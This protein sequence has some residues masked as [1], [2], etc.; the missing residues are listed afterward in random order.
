[1]SCID[2]SLGARPCALTWSTVPFGSPL[3]CMSNISPASCR[4]RSS[5]L[6]RQWDQF[7]LSTTRSL[8]DVEPSPKASF[9][10]IDD[11][12]WCYH[13]GT[14]YRLRSCYRRHRFC[15]VY[16]E[17][18]EGRFVLTTTHCSGIL[19]ASL[20]RGNYHSRTVRISGIW[21]VLQKFHG[22]NR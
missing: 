1:M 8:C 21:Y 12:L 4:V 15:T 3:L 22:E 7:V 13:L 20:I 6:I 2:I 5:T 9:R 19:V 10:V 16:A 14:H 18:K 17:L 11:T